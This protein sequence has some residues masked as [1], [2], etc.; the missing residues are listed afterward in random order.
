MLWKYSQFEQSSPKEH[1]SK[2]KDIAKELNMKQKMKERVVCFKTT[3]RIPFP[4]R[5]N[6]RKRARSTPKTCSSWLIF[7]PSLMK[8]YASSIQ[9]HSVGHPHTLQER[10][11]NQ[12][13]SIEEIAKG[14]WK[15]NEIIQQSSRKAISKM[16]FIPHQDVRKLLLSI[17]RF[18][19][20]LFS[21]L[22]SQF[23]SMI[24]LCE[25]MVR[26]RIEQ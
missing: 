3:A 4:C 25:D 23:I 24:N 19:I 12:E 14:I 5:K 26:S 7:I 18:I 8:M 6:S 9:T 10:R 17:C 22:S 20:V 21:R 16:I 2:E 13:I 1:N 11:G 15:A